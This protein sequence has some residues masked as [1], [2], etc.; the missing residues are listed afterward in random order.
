MWPVRPSRWVG[1]EQE[2]AVLGAAIE[3][4]GRGEGTVVWIEGEPLPP[5]PCG[6][7]GLLHAVTAADADMFGFAGV[8]TPGNPNFSVIAG[9]RA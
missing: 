9:G 3:A 8:N 6:D 4:L 7:G 2:L 5:S 1:R